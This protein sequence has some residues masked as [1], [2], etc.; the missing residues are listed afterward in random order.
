MRSLKSS[1]SA[2]CMN[3]VQTLLPSPSQA[4]VLPPDIAH[5]LFDGDEIGE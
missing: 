5:A 4:M 3:D 1:F 2:A